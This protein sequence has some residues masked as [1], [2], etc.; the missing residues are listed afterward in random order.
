MNSIKVTIGLSHSA[1]PTSM[2]L[3]APAGILTTFTLAAR[4]KSSPQ[5][6]D[7][8]TIQTE[9]TT[10][11]AHPTSFPGALIN[12]TIGLPSTTDSSR[13]ILPSP[14]VKISQGRNENPDL[15]AAEW[16]Y[17]EI[18]PAVGGGELV[19]WFGLTSDALVRNDRYSLGV[20]WRDIKPGERFRVDLRVWTP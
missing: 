14:P 17:F 8:I 7:P 5:P 13:Y 3:S 10:L 9:G 4:T 2:S 19:E 1:S 12:G 18:V 11:D 16:L 15:R 20:K 6:T